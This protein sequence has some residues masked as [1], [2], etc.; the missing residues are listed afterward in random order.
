MNR[1]IPFTFD[2]GVAVGAGLAEAII[3]NTYPI[4]Q[5]YLKMEYQH[6]G[7]PSSFFEFCK[8]N[9]IDVF[10]DSELENAIIHLY[11]LDFLPLEAKP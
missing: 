3:L 10:S 8:L 5:E 11:E 6:E 9:F 1:G 4:Y 2:I 7:L